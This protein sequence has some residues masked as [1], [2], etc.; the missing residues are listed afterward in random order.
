[1]KKSGQVTIF[2]IIAVVIVGAVGGYFL[3]RG[4]SSNEDR[5]Y[6]P[7]VEGVREFVQ[8]CFDEASLIGMYE[9]GEQK[10]PSTQNLNSEGLPYY[11]SGDQNLLPSKIDLGG[12]ISNY[13]LES[14]SLCIGDFENFENLEISSRQPSVN[15]EIENLK[16]STELNYDLN[17]KKIGSESSSNLKEAYSSEVDIKMGKM[18]EVIENIVSIDTTNEYG[19][20]LTC[21]NEL[22]EEN[23][24]NMENF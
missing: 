24:F 7:D 14:F 15:V 20:C 21:S 9:F 6:T 23:D 12:E 11:Y 5:I 1:M 3:L 8:D 22:L 2:I 13:I 10:N 18:Y 17:V 4:E 19:H 16:V